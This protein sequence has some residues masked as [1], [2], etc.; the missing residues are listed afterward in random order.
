MTLLHL[1]INESKDRCVCKETK[2]KNVKG[3]VVVSL[4]VAL[5]VFTATLSQWDIMAKDLSVIGFLCVF[6]QLA[7]RKFGGVYLSSPSQ[8]HETKDGTAVVVKGDDE[9][10][11]AKWPNVTHARA[12]SAQ[13]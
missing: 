11:D 4:R 3:M 2:K 12:D 13:E 8:I 10:G 9:T 6:A 7:M 1:G 5:I